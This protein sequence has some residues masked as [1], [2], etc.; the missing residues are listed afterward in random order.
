[1]PL[2][3]VGQTFS[4]FDIVLNSSVLPEVLHLKEPPLH[5]QLSTFLAVFRFLISAFIISMI[6]RNIFAIFP[7]DSLY[8]HI[9]HKS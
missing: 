6:L 5:Q 8:L 4:V 2:A 9:Y 3:E 7:F 1:M